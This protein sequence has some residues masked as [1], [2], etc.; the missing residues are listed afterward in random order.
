[1]TRAPARRTPAAVH[2]LPEQT[3]GLGAIARARHLEAAEVP[4][5][6]DRLPEL[7][8]LQERAAWHR[9][10]EQPAPG[11]RPPSCPSSTSAFTWRP[12]P[13]CPSRPSAWEPSPALAH[14][15]GQDAMG[16]YHAIGS[17]L[18]HEQQHRRADTGGHGF[19]LSDHFDCPTQARLLRRVS[20]SAPGHCAL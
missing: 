9:L 20:H 16:H 7:D 12:P 18:R 10:P 17:M 11:R 13:S 3:L 15:I 14:A 2:R 19:Y 1:M 6:V 4:A 5:A 8:Q